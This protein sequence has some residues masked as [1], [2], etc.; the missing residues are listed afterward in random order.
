MLSHV[1]TTSGDIYDPI[2]NTSASMSVAGST[3]KKCY[4]CGGPFHG[5]NNCKSCP[6]NNV[7]CHKCNKKGHFSKVCQSKSAS[8]AMF[9]PSLCAT[10]AACPLSLTHASLHVMVNGVKLTTLIDSCSSDSFISEQ[11]INNLNI[12][13]KPST[14]KVTM[15]LTSL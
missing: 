1:A 4:F 2:D 14:K 8:C 13:I 6:A 3:R 9:K 7:P 10:S 5:A 12:S 15:A 11:V